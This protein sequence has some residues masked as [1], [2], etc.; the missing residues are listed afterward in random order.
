MMDTRDIARI[1]E[2]GPPSARAALAASP[3]GQSAQRIASYSGL[4]LW[5]TT[6]GKRS[7]IM[8]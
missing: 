8:E 1:L 6:R 7:R 5:P 3:A 2:D 4:K